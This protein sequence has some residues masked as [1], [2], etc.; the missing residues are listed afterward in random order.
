ME[1]KNDDISEVLDWEA[2]DQAVRE[3]IKYP[4]FPVIDQI[5]DEIASGDVPEFDTLVATFPRSG[6]K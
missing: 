2:P 6:N 1:V 5:L 4:T 3:G